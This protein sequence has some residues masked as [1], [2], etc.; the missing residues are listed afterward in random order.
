MKGIF[1]SKSKTSERNHLYSVTAKPIHVGKELLPFQMY[2]KE[3]LN[4][5]ECPLLNIF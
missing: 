5:I 4:K 3:K 1:L 2:L